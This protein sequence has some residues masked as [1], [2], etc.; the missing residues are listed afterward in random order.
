MTS[1]ASRIALC[2]AALA[3]TAACTCND[4]QAPGASP[5]PSAPN[6]ETLAAATAAAPAAASKLPSG[7]T[8]DLSIPRAEV[9]D[10]GPP[11]KVSSYPIN[12]EAAMAQTGER[13]HGYFVHLFQHEVGQ[14]TYFYQS[15]APFLPDN[16]TGLR[17]WLG[18]ENDRNKTYELVA[19]ISREPSYP[20]VDDVRAS[21]KPE[22]TIL[23]TLRVTR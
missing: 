13:S 6:S 21:K 10:P 2:T 19:T 1:S 11:P 9:V 18:A 12:V 20:K 17:A 22:G 8:V 4:K 7:I 3:M 5:N 23:A 14:S 16:K 15:S